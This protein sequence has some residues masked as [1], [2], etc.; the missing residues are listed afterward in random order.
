MTTARKQTTKRSGKA[1][2]SDSQPRANRSAATLA[3]GQ[4]DISISEF[5]AKNRHLLGFDNPRKA[6]LTTVKEAVDNALDACEEA[7]NLPEIIVKIEHLPKI[8]ENRYRIT[9]EDNGPG[10]VRSQID[11]IFGKL[12]YGSKFHRLKMSRGQQ[13]IGISAAG[14]YGLM[15]TGKPMV[16]VTRS[17]KGKPAHHVE[18][19]M[20]TTKNRPEVAVDKDTED[21]PLHTGTRVSIE[22]EGRYSKGKTSVDEYLEQ[23]AIANPHVRFIYTP[24]TR[25]ENNNEE[26]L[27]TN[28]DDDDSPSPE[29]PIPGFSKR[30][31]DSIDSTT[32]VGDTIIYPRTVD[33]LP[34]E[35][36][37]I[38]PHPRGVELGT[39]LR[40]LKQTNEKNVGPFL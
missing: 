40:M 7:G 10:V 16:I 12:L 37:E 8:D 6:L 32:K 31:L 27:N 30:E 11:N 14:M 4:R 39:L 3:A 19:A 34:D 29:I 18:L 35:P 24:P 22:L 13:G 25:S 26:Q 5:F 1:D 15:T 23:T 36:I 28:L 38:K 9:V 21:F 20:D 33:H 17:K 2:R